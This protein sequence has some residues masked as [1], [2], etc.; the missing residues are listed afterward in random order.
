MRFLPSASSQI[1]S[2]ANET[3]VPR[4]EPE[5]PAEVANAE[6]PTL[7]PKT[8]P[9]ELVIRL[10]SLSGGR[11]AGAGAPQPLGHVERQHR[12]VPQIELGDLAGHLLARRQLAR[13]IGSESAAS[14][15]L[16]RANRSIAAGVKSEV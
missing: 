1:G 11:L 4:A 10:S 15:T 12:L 16:S 2:T 9:S 6:A 5:N 3:C 8:A 7:R 13:W 14:S